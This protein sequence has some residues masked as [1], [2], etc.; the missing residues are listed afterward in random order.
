M[1]PGPGRAAARPPGRGTAAG[2]RQ[3]LPR[4]CGAAAAERAGGCRHPRP[5]A[6]LRG[7]RR[8]AAAGLSAAAAA[9][10]G[11]PRPCASPPPGCRVPAERVSERPWRGRGA[12]VRQR[13][14]QPARARAGESGRPL[15]EGSRD[16][17]RRPCPEAAERRGRPGARPPLSAVPG[18]AVPPRGGWGLAA[19]PRFAAVCGE[20]GRRQLLQVVV[21]FVWEAG[22]TRSV[23]W[24]TRAAA[25]SR[26]LRGGA[27][28]R[29]AA[30]RCRCGHLRARLTPAGAALPAP[31]PRPG[32]LPPAQSAGRFR[33]ALT[34][35][36]RQRE[37][38]CGRNCYIR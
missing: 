28:E 12:A 4:S 35:I 22:V 13:C 32:R 3:K 18:R 20:G 8:A 21:G 29:G 14:P 10:R 9:P 16:A 26:Q 17:A 7:A 5:P 1:A 30:R 38:L 11:A 23:L 24:F 2:R 34:L 6:A 19:G 27:G 31:A 33:V 25:P 36:N 15:R 37:R